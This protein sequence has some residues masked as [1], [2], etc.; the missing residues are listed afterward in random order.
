MIYSSWPETGTNNGVGLN[1]LMGSQLII[2]TKR[3]NGT[4]IVIK[5]YTSHMT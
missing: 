5:K 4:V 1:Q 3:D 2:S